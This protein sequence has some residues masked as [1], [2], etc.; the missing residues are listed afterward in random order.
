MQGNPY[1]TYYSNQAGSGISGFQGVRFQRGAGFF[2]NV[3]KSAILPLLK[4]FGRQALSTG[5]EIAT[6][7]LDGENV[8][9]SMKKR[10]KQAAK[11]IAM[12]ASDRAQ[13][14]VQTGKGR[15]RRRRQTVARPVVRPV[16]RRVQKGGSIRKSRKPKATVRQKRTV[17]RNRSIPSIF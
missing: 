3:F 12:D 7:A 17:T 13:R 8:L 5:T 15:K 16:A 9:E 1:I 4:Y 10:G 2:G 11:N 6:D 14:F